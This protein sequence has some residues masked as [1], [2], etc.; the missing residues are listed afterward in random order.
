MKSLLYHRPRLN[1]ASTHIQWIDPL[2]GLMEL[3]GLSSRCCLYV[4]AVACLESEHNELPLLFL[5]T[6]LRV[7][8]M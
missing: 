7:C 4:V 5:L 8:M 2:L 1:Y 3:L 6:M